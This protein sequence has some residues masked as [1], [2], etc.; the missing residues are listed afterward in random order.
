MRERAGEHGQRN[1][2]EVVES[3]ADTKQPRGTLDEKRIGLYAV[4]IG[5]H[6]V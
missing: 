1:V 3:P 4:C 6:G 2:I 5:T